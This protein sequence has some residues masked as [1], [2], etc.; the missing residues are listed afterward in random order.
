[1]CVLRVLLRRRLVGHLGV[2][3][4]GI[5]VGARTHAAHAAAHAAAA[6]TAEAA[7]SVPCRASVV[8]ATL[9]AIAYK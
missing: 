5:E 1:M 7:R 9:V 8:G 6:A 3:S 2:E 4:V